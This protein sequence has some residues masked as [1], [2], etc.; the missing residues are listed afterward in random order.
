[1]EGS[2]VSVMSVPVSN[3]DVAKMFYTDVLGMEVV[4]DDRDVR[5]RWIMLRPPAGQTAV[6]LVTWFETMP[7]GSL[8]GSVLAV[9]DIEAA[10]AVLRAKG[11][12][13]EDEQIMDAPW[14]RY[15]TVEDPDGNGWIIQQNAETDT[16]ELNGRLGP[17][18]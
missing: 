8:R 7:M 6:T 18:G 16:T 12:I 10:V 3:P 5:L 1:V 17:D 14:G 4:R 11:A 15:V 13:E 2:Y 9:P